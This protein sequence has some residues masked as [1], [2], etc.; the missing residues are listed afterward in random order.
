MDSASGRASHPV[1][2]VRYDDA[3]AYC[4]WLS[5]SLGRV[6]RLPT[7]A[8]WEKAARGGLEGLKCPWGNDIDQTKCNFLTTRMRSVSAARDQQEP[9]RRTRGLYATCRATWGGYPI[10]D[11]PSMHGLGE[12]RDPQGP[13]SGAMRIV[14]GGSWVN[15]DASMLRSAI[16]TKCR[17][18]RMLIAW[19]FESYAYPDHTLSRVR[20]DGR[21]SGTAPQVP[22]IVTVGEAVVRR[23]PIWHPS[24]SVWRRGRKAR[25]TRSVSMR[26]R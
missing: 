22:V 21:G 7:E 23:T 6:V 16:G 1:V 10:G 12:S 18:T 13:D 17:P 25:V 24:R 2:L 11:I 19:V 14:R 20:R 26:K 8:E 15:E 9:I 3:L 4:R 5:E